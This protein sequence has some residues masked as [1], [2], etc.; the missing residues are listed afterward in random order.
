M[1]AKT[2]IN[3]AM[4]AFITKHT[5]TPDTPDTPPFRNRPDNHGSYVLL[6]R[7][8]PLLTSEV[9]DTDALQ[10]IPALVQQPAYI[11]V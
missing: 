11:T 8:V 6:H 7:V 2:N 1:T 9:D 4:T 3:T 10:T 5:D